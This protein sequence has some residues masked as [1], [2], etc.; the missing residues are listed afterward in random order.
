MDEKLIEKVADDLFDPLTLTD[1]DLMGGIRR[2]TG[3]CSATPL[4]C[5][6]SL[7]NVAVQPLMEAI[8]TCLPGPIE[9]ALPM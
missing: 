1:V 2:L 9:R 4:L 5:G 7:Q 6:S 8:V 3:S